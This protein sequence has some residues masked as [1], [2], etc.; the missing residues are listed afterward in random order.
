MELLG[1]FV[2]RTELAKK[3]EQI[4]EEYLAC[5]ENQKPVK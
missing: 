1:K 4:C 3:H 2:V 5:S